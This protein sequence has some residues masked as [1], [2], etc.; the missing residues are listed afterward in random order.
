VLIYVRLVPKNVKNLRVKA[1]HA[2]FAQ[3][4]AEHVLNIHLRLPAKQWK[5]TTIKVKACNPA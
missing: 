3:R 2:K 5:K 4:P 1:R